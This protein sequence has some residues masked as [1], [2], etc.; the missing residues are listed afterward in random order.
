MNKDIYAFNQEQDVLREVVDTST[1]YVGFAK[2]GTLASETKW[3]IIKISSTAGEVISVR[4]AE[5]DNAY[6]FEW[7]ERASY[8][9]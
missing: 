7:D 1:T 9:Y 8:T 5:G 2:P 6:T 3:R 4:H